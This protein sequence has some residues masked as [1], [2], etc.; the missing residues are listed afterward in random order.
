MICI[1]QVLQHPSVKTKSHAQFIQGVQIHDYAWELF[2][3]PSY[4]E[5]GELGY[6]L[7]LLFP[8]IFLLHILGT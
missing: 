7:D 5:F 8:K 1:Q 4:I 2:P 6:K 3:F